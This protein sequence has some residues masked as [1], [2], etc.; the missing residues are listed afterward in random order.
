MEGDALHVRLGA[1]QRRE[2]RMPRPVPDLDLTLYG[3]ARHQALAIG[4]ELHFLDGRSVAAES[5]L[6]HAGLHVPDSHRLVRA[7]VG[8]VMAI[9]TEGQTKNRAGASRKTLHRP[10]LQ[11]IRLHLPDLNHAVAA[12]GSEEFAVGPERDAEN[13]TG[14]AR[15]FMQ[16]LS[17]IGIPET[18][19]RIF[20]PRGQQP[21]GWVE[22]DAVKALT[23]GR[24]Q[25]MLNR[26]GVGVP[27]FHL[28][29]FKRRKIARA[30]AAEAAFLPSALN[31]NPATRLV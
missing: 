6:S 12:G 17:R 13:R 24:P 14:V 22:G 11:G 18:H 29:P 21:A 23:I 15:Q 2:L 25:G 26:P 30:M 19:M 7:A 27:H 28:A 10:G 5:D 9:G 16:L 20:S 8:E 1:Y 4:T 3:T 31:D